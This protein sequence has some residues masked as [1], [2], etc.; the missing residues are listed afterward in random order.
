MP[1]VTIR[2]PREYA[3]LVCQEIDKRNHSAL[4]HFVRDE[5]DEIY[6]AFSDARRLERAMQYGRVGMT[7]VPDEVSGFDVSPKVAE[8][9]AWLMEDVKRV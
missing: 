3:E 7:V 6:D 2:I 5:L 4:P 8:A 1:K 9:M